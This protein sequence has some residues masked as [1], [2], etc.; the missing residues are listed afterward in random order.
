MVGFFVVVCLFF[1]YFDCVE[2][3]W[4]LLSSNDFLRFLRAK[5]NDL[6]NSPWSS[7]Y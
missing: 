5:G 3:V 4:R 7:S 6:G 2:M 1:F